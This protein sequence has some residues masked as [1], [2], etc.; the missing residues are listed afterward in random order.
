M[1]QSEGVLINNLFSANRAEVN[2]GGIYINEPSGPITL[3][4][5]RVELNKAQS[6]GGI[7]YNCGQENNQPIAFDGVELYRNNSSEEGGGMVISGGSPF[8]IG[9]RIE[10][11]F[12]AI[13]GGLFFG[14]CFEKSPYL[15]STSILHNKAHKGGGVAFLDDSRVNLSRDDLNRCNI[16]LNQSAEKGA[17][18]WAGTSDQIYEIVLDTFTVACPCLH[19]ACSLSCFD[20][21]ILNGFGLAGDYDVYV[22]PQGD[23]SNSG[24]T[25]EDPMKNLSHIAFKFCLDTLPPHRVFLSEGLYSLSSTGEQFPM[26]LWGEME[27]TGET[28]DG[29]I[30]DGEFSV[31]F[32]LKTDSGA[33]RF[34]Y[35]TFTSAL[36]DNSGGLLYSSAGGTLEFSEV[37]VDSC[38]ASKGGA[39][40]GMIDTLKISHSNFHRNV[41]WL[42]GGAIALI[43][44]YTVLED[45]TFLNNTAS[46]G[47]AVN[48][49]NI[50]GVWKQVNFLE[51][52][53]QGGGGAY[54]FGKLDLNCSD[55]RF[56]GNTASNT[57]GGMYTDYCNSTLRNMF[58]SGNQA[59]YGG[60][61][62]V[63]R[64]D[65]VLYNLC[66]DGN[67]ASKEGAAFYSVQS[68]VDADHLTIAGNENTSGKSAI[69]LSGSAV[70]LPDTINMKNLIY[71][72]NPGSGIRSVA[73]YV[74][75]NNCDIEGGRDAFTLSYSQLYW[76]HANIDAD[77]LFAMNGD[78]P[79]ELLPGSPCIDAAMLPLP[80]QKQNPFDIRGNF[81]CIDGNGD[82]F[83]VE[84]MGAYEFEGIRTPTEEPAAPSNGSLVVFPNPVNS[85]ANIVFSA[86]SGEKVRLDLCNLEGSLIWTIEVPSCSQGENKIVFNSEGLPPG[87][88]FLRMVS[89]NSS[90]A[91]KI[92]VAE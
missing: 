4:N 38:T 3:I 2:G 76:Q 29:T 77:P 41:A 42:E 45:V 64:S 6:G 60:G 71:W 46:R 59:R 58:F 15:S 74:R 47:G 10:E 44:T 17:D 66:F 11:N 81:R 21:D 86:V 37:T 54:I 50:S 73:C 24:Y 61:L 85:Y 65:A 1:W 55:V 72:G 7:Y 32:F 80:G 26:E 75:V 63:Y 89:E 48:L 70:T 43:N 30:L 39:I 91:V 68:D 83:R 27:L 23:N 69:F 28:R 40:A 16:Y 52:H 51:N 19:F 12:A 53:A 82:G 84:D 9:C 13:G 49:S 18:L 22:S 25:P 79:L 8:L 88:Y 62:R 5:N 87:I 14:N 90:Y 78:H 31:P 57:G 33:D 20:F 56:I 67:L 34:S 36:S 92:V 35:L